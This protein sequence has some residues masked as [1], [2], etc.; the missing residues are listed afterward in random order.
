L[1]AAIGLVIAMAGE[2][3]RGFDVDKLEKAERR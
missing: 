1:A 2:R 3:G